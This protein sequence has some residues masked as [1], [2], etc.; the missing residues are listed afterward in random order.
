MRVTKIDRLAEMVWDAKSNG[1]ESA[2]ALL[3]DCVNALFEAHYVC[4]STRD[5]LMDQFNVEEV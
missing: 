4:E 1:D 5:W 3:E 2:L